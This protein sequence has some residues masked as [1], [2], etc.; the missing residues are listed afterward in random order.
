MPQYE[1][2]PRLT[3]SELEAALVRDD[4]EELARHVLSAALYLDDAAMATAYCVR[5]ADHADP[6]VRGNALLGFAHIARIHRS[7]DRACSVPLVQ[8][9]RNDTHEWVRMQAR[10]AVEDFVHYLGWTD[11]VAAT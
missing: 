3:W 6:T 10:N 7:L 5:L 2:L 9:G 11:L 8:R 1:S 4:P